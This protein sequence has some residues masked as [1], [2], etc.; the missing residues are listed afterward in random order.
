M[1]L[2]TNGS[3][4]AQAEVKKL[5]AA[6]LDFEDREEKARLE[7]AALRESL[8]GIALADAMGEEPATG[9]AGLDGKRSAMSARNRVFK[10]EQEINTFGAAMLALCSKLEEALR[11]CNTAKAGEIRKQADKLRRELSTHQAES[12]RLLSL[13]HDHEGV[14]F[15]PATRILPLQ[16]NA[17]IKGSTTGGTKVVEDLAVVP[18]GTSKSEALTDQIAKLEAEAKKLET[19][20]VN[21]GG[22]IVGKATLEEVLAD[23]AAVDDIVPTER[24]VRTWYAAA[25]A[26]A[27]AAWTKHI[28]VN[29]PREKVESECSITVQWSKDAVLAAG[30]AVVFRQ[31]V[32]WQRVAYYGAAR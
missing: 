2:F 4:K 12:D 17:G 30:S 19:R 18:E 20:Q 23:I 15:V 32:A 3:A 9:P 11:A 14:D 5:L 16:G 8:P 1:P 24:A 25:F 10:L 27:E 31:R 21:V 28:A 7:L 26:E 13:L 29:F 22:A 6:R